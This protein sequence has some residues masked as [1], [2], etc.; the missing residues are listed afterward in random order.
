MLCI[1]A[2]F[3]L[4]V[5][6]FREIVDLTPFWPLFD[7]LGAQKYPWG[8]GKITPLRFSVL[9]VHNLDVST[10]KSILASKSHGITQDTPLYMTSMDLPYEKH[11]AQ[12]NK[13]EL[14]VVLIHKWSVALH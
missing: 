9:V 10:K 3:K 6:I 14:R 13:A 11:N 2:K 12:Q 7:P 5:M 1:T 8:V 4:Q